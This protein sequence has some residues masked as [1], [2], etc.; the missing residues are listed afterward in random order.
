M[1]PLESR[2][3]VRSFTTVTV[4]PSAR[5]RSH[6]VASFSVNG[7]PAL[8]GTAMLSSTSRVP[9]VVRLTQQATVPSYQGVQANC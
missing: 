7:A 1:R 4:F 8:G 5:G 2:A 9:P 3:I 6:S